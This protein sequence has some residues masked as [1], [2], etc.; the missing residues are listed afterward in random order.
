MNPGVFIYLLEIQF[1]DGVVK[2]YKGDVSIIK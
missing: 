2:M 1:V